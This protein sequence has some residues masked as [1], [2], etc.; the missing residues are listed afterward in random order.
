MTFKKLTAAEGLICRVGMGSGLIAQAHF[1]KTL[2][3]LF[4]YPRPSSKN[5]PNI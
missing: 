2:N 5:D 1:N 3:E 4:F